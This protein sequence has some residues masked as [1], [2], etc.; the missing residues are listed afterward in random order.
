MTRF[1]LAQLYFESLRDKRTPWIL[2]NALKD[3]PKGSNALDQAYEEAIRRIKEQERGFA[4]VAWRLLSWITCA[5]RPL[6]SKELEHALAVVAGYP[7]LP[8]DNLQDIEDIVSL[9]AG[10]VTIDEKSDIVRLVHYTTQEYFIRNSLFP[11]AQNDIAEVC[12]TYLSFK[13]FEAGFCATKT[14]FEERLQLH[15][16]YSYAARYWGK[17]ARA[18]STKVEHLTLGFLKSEQKVSAAGQAMIAS[19][20]HYSERK[21]GKITGVHLAEFFELNKA[22]LALFENGHHIDTKDSYGQTPLSWA[23]ENGHEEGVSLLLD[24][25]AEI[26]SKDIYDQRPLLW[27]IRNGH[28]KAARWLLQRG[29]EI[30]FKDKGGGTLLLWAARKGHESEMK[31]LLE[32]GAKIESKDKNGQSPLLWAARNG[33]ERAAKLLLE[34]G[35]KIDSRDNDGR[36]PISWAVAVKKG[37]EAVVRL[38]LENGADFDSK[39]NDGRTPLSWAARNGHETLVRLLL[40]KGADFESRD[41]KRRTPLLWAREKRYNV[42]ERLLREQGAK[43]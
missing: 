22:I 31:L 3:L 9:C 24:M 7:E 27:A 28:K 38:L 20:P 41:N 32:M 18:A 39:D 37:H 35:V 19:F 40:E 34:Q 30:D 5:E 42:V 23:A 10:L 21:P 25:G 29:A 11:D 26:E 1:L 12:I 14:E 16:F 8:T 43:T 36:T 2:K 17:H 4:E 6:T 13:A 15:P 33:H